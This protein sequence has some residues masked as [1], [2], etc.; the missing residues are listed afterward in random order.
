MARLLK[1]G[2]DFFG[3]A[4]F[5]HVLIGEYCD[6]SDLNFGSVQ[7]QTSKIVYYP[8]PVAFYGL[9][10]TSF[11]NSI[12]RKPCY[13]NLERLINNYFDIIYVIL[14]IALVTPRYLASCV[15]YYVSSP[16]LQKLES[17]GKLIFS[18]VTSEIVEQ[19]DNLLLQLPLPFTLSKIFVGKLT[20]FISIG[21][22]TRYR[23][24]VVYGVDKNRDEAPAASPSRAT[25]RTSP[26]G[27]AAA[28]PPPPGATPRTSRPPVTTPLP[29]PPP[30]PPVTATSPPPGAT[31]RT[32]RPSVTTPPP[33]T[34]PPTP[35]PTPPPPPPP[36]SSK[37]VTNAKNTITYS[38]NPTTDLHQFLTPDDLQAYTFYNV[39]IHFPNS[40]T[41]DD[42]QK[43]KLDYV[44]LTNQYYLKNLFHNDKMFPLEIG[45]L[46]AYLLKLQQYSSRVTDFHYLK[47]I[48]GLFIVQLLEELDKNQPVKN[49][50]IEAYL[51]GKQSTQI[52]AAV[53]PLL[54]K[55]IR[56]VLPTIT[57][58]QA[59]ELL[60]QLQHEI[61]TVFKP[62]IQH[63]L[64]HEYKLYYRRFEKLIDTLKEETLNN[65]STPQ[66]EKKH[67]MAFLRN[68]TKDAQFDNIVRYVSISLFDNKQRLLRAYLK[69][70][71]RVVQQKLRQ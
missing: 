53:K 7:E 46:L 44:Q 14:P 49:T 63:Y 45:R 67:T 9:K 33:P 17:R 11:T 47:T 16:V 27:T 37:L 36:G 59:T 21:E 70:N 56:N 38:F 1:E 6:V 69:N 39:L 5:K 31:P 25:S 35:T 42:S 50:L 23:E 22:D 68:D 26:P 40:P 71:Q 57:T 55:N 19:I 60:T 52:D 15:E 20:T 65:A 28:A 2:S 12:T 3:N 51:N 48:S 10:F 13:D 29:P 54:L 32:S 18:N 24:A 61:K 58:P 64:V 34:P 41:P 30:P 43:V 4:N 66:E 62:M 8:A